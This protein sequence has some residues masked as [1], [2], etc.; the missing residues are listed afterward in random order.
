M[1]RIQGI[2]LHIFSSYF[3][4]ILYIPRMTII[5]MAKGQAEFAVI[6]GIVIVAAVVIIYALPNITNPIIPSG[7]YGMF[8]AS[9]ER[10]VR[11]GAQDT[12]SRLSAY[13]GYHT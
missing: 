4:C 10:L 12:M 1:N 7:T 3:F 2:F 8:K 11:A 9:F 6:I 13:G 5:S